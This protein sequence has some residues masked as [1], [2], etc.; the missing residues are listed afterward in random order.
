M[1]TRVTTLWPHLVGALLLGGI[2]AAP[3]RAQVAAPK[4]VEESEE[5]TEE[6][7]QEPARPPSR[8]GQ[9]APAPAPG[10]APPTTGQAAP[11][12]SPAPG[13]AVV[14]PPPPPP[15]APTA[16]LVREIMPVKVTQ[17][18]LLAHWTARRVAV[19]EGDPVKAEQA[20]QELL[21][22]KR[23]LGIDDLD[24]MSA[25]EV[26]ESRRALQQNG[27]ARALA[28]AELA[29]E[30]A[31]DQADAHLALA[32]ARLAHAPGD[33][34]QVF[35]ALGG[36]LG[37]GAR[38]P[39]TARAFVADVVGAGLVAVFLAALAVV[40]VLLARHLRRL[41]HDLQHL[42]LVGAAGVQAAFLALILLAA[43]AVLGAG[44]FL[45]VAV[46]ALASF[47]YQSARERLVTLAAVA[48]IAAMPWA[49]GVVARQ[50]W[51]T[52]T[53][54]E[55][56]DAFERGSPSAEEAAALAA[57]ANDAPAP[58]MVHAALGRYHK[59]R[60]ELDEALRLY[61][62]AAEADPRAADVSV[63][64]GNVLLLRGDVEGAKAAYL[65][66]TDRA[67][68]DLVVLAAAHYNLSKLYLRTSDMEKS[69][70][71]RERAESEG[72]DFLRRY[73]SDDDFSANRYVVDVPVSRE[74]LVTMAR[75]EAN[76]ELVRN[77]LRARLAGTL[78]GAWLTGASA[79]LAALLGASALAARRLMPSRACE[80]CG[81]ASCRR[82]DRNAAGMCG[83]CINVFTRKG[84]V[85]AR[86]RL[87]K[88]SEVRR[89]ERWSRLSTRALAIAGGGVGQLW[90]GRPFLGTVLVLGMLFLAVVVGLWR[91]LLPPPLPTPY[92]LGGKLLVALPLGLG[93]WLVAV[94]DAFRRTE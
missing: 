13:D 53:L 60:G 20:A 12:A 82:C 24:A 55:Q 74:R 39:H 47:M 87:R 26:R 27:S 89:H 58:A 94:R 63:N 70:A 83:A 88:E 41:L 36:A 52:G 16:E 66:A 18:T 17:D 30:L 69:A 11:A 76:P 4:L 32:R 6:P 93:F 81:G 71:A 34:G 84:V 91:G 50:T 28:H 45:V 9:A 31:P 61:Q 86:D 56:I 42:P 64:T 65:S 79:L 7:Q 29:V 19:R 54:A 59:R 80:R 62:R 77:W 67:G 49:A 48:A 2:L 72:A 90:S 25:A 85:D 3:A 14:P 40:T 46:W 57:R 51:W 78:P 73:G 10:T 15:P 35:A 68:G 75:D 5:T 33:P 37:A 8:P 44:P 21:A 22:V 1:R 92:V 38:D 43:P 23:A